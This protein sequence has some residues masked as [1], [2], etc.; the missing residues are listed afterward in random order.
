MEIYDDRARNGNFQ[1][2][3]KEVEGAFGPFPEFLSLLPETLQDV[4]TEADPRLLEFLTGLFSRPEPADG[5]LLATHEE[6][7]RA[8]IHAMLGLAEKGAGGDPHLQLRRAVVRYLRHAGAHE[9]W[10]A[11]VIAVLDRIRQTP[12]SELGSE[13]EQVLREIRPP[14]PDRPVLDDAP[15]VPRASRKVKPVAAPPVVDYAE[16]GRLAQQMG[17]ELQAAMARLLAGPASPEEKMREATRMSEEYQAKI[18][19]LYNT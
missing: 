15:R 3:P 8:L 17:L 4:A 14:E 13:C 12:R 16:K 19:A 7:G 10:R 2:R 6:A 18:K 11:E 9:G 5:A 1:L